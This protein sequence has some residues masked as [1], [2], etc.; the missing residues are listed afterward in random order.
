MAGTTARASRRDMMHTTA[1]QDVVRGLR[2]IL[3]QPQHATTLAKARRVVRSGAPVSQLVLAQALVALA[4]AVHEA[5][6]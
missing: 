5:P 3:E 4:D 6:E 1:E 2:S